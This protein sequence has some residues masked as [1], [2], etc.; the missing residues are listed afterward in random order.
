MSLEKFATLEGKCQTLFSKLKY[1]T[2]S[3]TN[4]IDNHQL[5][6][7]NSEIEKTQREVKALILNMDAEAKSMPPSNKRAS[8][9]KISSLRNEL[10]VITASIQVAN[11]NRS[12]MNLL[13]NASKRVRFL[14]DF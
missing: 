8:L 11:E 13:G 3:I 1:S 12:R 9:S 14:I 10:G 2:E 7:V 6:A 4:A 5:H